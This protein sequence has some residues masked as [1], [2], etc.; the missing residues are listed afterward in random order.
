MDGEW[1][2]I[3]QTKELSYE[4]KIEK[5]LIKAM[6]DDDKQ[7]IY[8]MLSEYWFEISNDMKIRVKEM[9]KDYE[10]IRGIYNY[11]KKK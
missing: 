6:H 5:E 7:K 1:P 4:K 8:E 3:K 11:I 2:P 10:P 9:Y